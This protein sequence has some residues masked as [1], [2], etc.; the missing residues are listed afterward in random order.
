MPLEEK[1]HTD[2]SYNLFRDIFLAHLRSS[3]RYSH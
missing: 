3:E 1:L 2:K